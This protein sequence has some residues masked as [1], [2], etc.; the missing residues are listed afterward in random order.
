MVGRIRSVFRLVAV[1][2][3]LLL[4]A[5]SQ[6][7]GDGSKGDAQTQPVAKGQR[8]FTC[9]HSFHVWVVPI[10]SEMAKAAGLDGHEVV[11]VSR[12]GGSRV[13]QH[14]DVPEEKNEAKKALRAGKVDVLTLS[15]IWLPEEGI[16]K[17]ATLALEH[18]PNIQV[19]VQEYWLPND[20]YVPVYPL[21]T[22]KKVDHDAANLAE[23]RKNQTRY[24]HDVDEFVRS[25]NKRLGKD[26]IVTVPVGQAV[27]ALREKIV[28]RKAPGLKTQAELFRDSWGHPTA[29]VQA[30]AA[31]CHFAV[32]YRRSP[33][34]LPLPTIL[35]MNPDWDNKLNRL[36]QELAWDAV[37]HHPL[38]GV[39]VKHNAKSTPFF[40][41]P[42]RATGSC[43]GFHPK[44]ND[45]AVSHSPL[46]RL[47]DM[48]NS[49][50][51]L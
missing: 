42:I 12:I 3:V 49:P 6:A 19:T 17:F 14:W 26:V 50:W 37:I 23:L 2:S 43:T 36:L 15:P 40:H 5:L 8:V 51:R 9:G 4:V 10:L 39:R 22:K 20:E 28:A 32:I 1:V 13:I 30:L 7:N 16:K 34:G 41:P 35:T 25:I 45:L 27:L 47:L 38:S 24:D 46:A 33:V 44:S 11:G 48:P 29:P 18:N 21:Q 31:Y